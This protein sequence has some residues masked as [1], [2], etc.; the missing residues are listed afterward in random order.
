MKTLKIRVP[1]T[2]SAGN[3]TLKLTFKDTVPG[4]TV[5]VKKTVRIPR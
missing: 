3:A 1:R 4:Q 5:V 2:L